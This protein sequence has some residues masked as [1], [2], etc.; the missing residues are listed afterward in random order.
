MVIPTDGD[1]QS[2]SAFAN[3]IQTWLS[4]HRTTAK[5]YGLWRKFYGQLGEAFALLELHNKMQ[6]KKAKIEW[7]GGQNKDYDVKITDQSGAKLNIQ[8][9]ASHEGKSFR[10]FTYE[11][12]RSR[13]KHA[14]AKEYKKKKDNFKLPRTISALFDKQVDERFV[15]HDRE[16]CFWIFVSTGESGNK[17]FILDKQELKSLMK[18]DYE[19]YIRKKPHRKDF[20]YAITKR[21]KM[22]IILKTKVMEAHTNR[23]DKILK[24][25]S[26]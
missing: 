13:E 14:I 17:F 24:Y 3:T 26:S 12:I 22:M 9:K 23:W 2:L 19:R 10:P 21:G 5:E 11:K 20:N 25:L 8:I 4:G 18:K 7:F 6:D 1:L 15:E 16:K